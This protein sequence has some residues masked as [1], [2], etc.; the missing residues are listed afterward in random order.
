MQS[1]ILK[2]TVSTCYKAQPPFSTRSWMTPFKHELPTSSTLHTSKSPAI[3]KCLCIPQLK[4][5]SPACNLSTF[6]GPSVTYL[7]NSGSNRGGFTTIPHFT[8]SNKGQHFFT[9]KRHFSTDP[10]YNFFSIDFL[11]IKISHDLF[12]NIYTFTGLPWWASIALTTVLLRSCITLPLA[13]Y[14]NYILARVENLQPE[15]R[16]LSHRLKIETAKAIREFG[17]SMEH[18]RKRYNY[19]MKKVIRELYIQENC[20]PGKATV[21]I[22]VQIPMWIALSFTLRYMSGFAPIMDLDSS[23]IHSEL[24]HEGML[25]FK[26]MTLPDRTWILPITLGLVNLSI[27]EIHALQRTNSTFL[28]KIITNLVRG[29]S[30]LMIPIGASVPSCMCWYW[31]CSSLYGLSQNLAFLLPT[32]RRAV[33]IPVTPSEC[34]TPYQRLY[35]AAKE[36]YSFKRKK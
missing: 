10:I 19:S 25:W 30:F 6:C 33:R 34:G 14:S 27:I 17:W 32:V 4:R 29:L 16:K 24:H 36:K 31:L 13:V 35:A 11:P 3:L 23:F 20:H 5:F 21:L 9:Q 12:V 1:Q 26:D 8:V 15:I 22:W 2:V 18:A 7:Y 28:T